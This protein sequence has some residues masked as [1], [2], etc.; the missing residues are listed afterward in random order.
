MPR[1]KYL[2]TSCSHTS[3]RVTVH[4]DFDYQSYTFTIH[5]AAVTVKPPLP[6]SPYAMNAE[7]IIRLTVSHL[8]SDYRPA[9]RLGDDA[10]SVQLK[11]A[12]YDLCAYFGLPHTLIADWDFIPRF[13]PGTPE[14][15]ARKMARAAHA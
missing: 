7:R 3:S 14:Y 15:I 12:G 11:L 6:F 1:K 13:W 10:R 9:R 8:K 2:Y 5:G 4:T